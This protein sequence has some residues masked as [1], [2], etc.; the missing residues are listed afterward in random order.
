MKKTKVL[1]VLI[2]V[3]LVI[4]VIQTAPIMGVYGVEPDV[5]TDSLSN[6]DNVWDY[7]TRTVSTFQLDNVGGDRTVV[8]DYN[9]F[10][11]LKDSGGTM[12]A[13]PSL[14]WKVNGG[15]KVEVMAYYWNT[16]YNYTLSWSA[17]GYDY[18]VIDPGSMQIDLI[19]SENAAAKGVGDEYISTTE[20]T[21]LYTIDQ[22]DASARFLKVTWP[23]ISDNWKA[24]LSMVRMTGG[25]E[26]AIDM[27]YDKEVLISNDQTADTADMAAYSQSFDFDQTV[28]GNPVLMVSWGYLSGKAS[29]EKPYIVYEADHSKSF[30]A[31]FR[32]HESFFHMNSEINFYSSESLSGPWTQVYP[33]RQR[34]NSTTDVN[35]AHLN[36]TVADL[37]EGGRYVKIEYPF[38][39]D[40][41]AVPWGDGTPGTPGNPLTYMCSM[42]NVKYTEY[43]VPPITDIEADT[44]SDF[45]GNQESDTT[46]WYDY[47]KNIFDYNQKVAGVPFLALDWYAV[48][49]KET[50]PEIFVIYKVKAGSPFK[51]TYVRHARFINLDLNIKIFTS[52]DASVWEERTDMIFSSEPS[53]AAP[54]FNNEMLITEA[55]P[56]THKFVKVVYPNTKDYSGT[57][58]PVE[59]DTIGDP[60]TYGVGIISAKYNVTDESPE[61]D[62]LTTV[63]FEGDEAADTAKWA[64]YAKNTFDFVQALEG[65]P[66]LS[67]R[68]DFV[69]EKETLP[70]A[71]VVYKTAPGSPFVINSITH[72]KM[73]DMGK[74]Y[75]VYTSEDMA[76]WTEVTELDYEYAAKSNDWYD[77]EFTIQNIPETHQYVKIVWPNEKDYTG[78]QNPSREEV[79]GDPIHYAPGLTGVRLILPEPETPETPDISYIT[80][81]TTITYS[82]DQEA[83]SAKMSGYNADAIDFTQMLQVGT[84]NLNVLMLNYDFVLGQD[85]LPEAYVAYKVAS[86]SPFRVEGFNHSNALAL[87]LDFILMGSENGTDWTL[88]EDVIYVEEEVEDVM[89]WMKVGF[90]IEQ[91]PAGIQYVKIVWPNEKDYTGDINPEDSTTLDTLNYAPALLSVTFNAAEA[92]DD[93]ENPQ[94]GDNAV[95]FTVVL[96]VS[97][98]AAAAVIAGRKQK[99]K[100]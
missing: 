64:D 72:R 99:I 57:P 62:D 88:L 69:F 86:G 18:T 12:V 55:I 33:S 6:L 16:S 14:V 68:Y 22:I 7:N 37:P 15:A 34:V 23:I 60:I 93:E 53:E 29:V 84:T 82:G 35:V 96:L 20:T 30:M 91:L 51:L 98:V 2:S 11:T 13:R 83:D 9:A 26:N 17:N 28:D 66:F 59:G 49:G 80:G 19:S 56:A 43:V 45:Q 39:K 10:N 41:S 71:Y 58:D 65:L 4:S 27:T 100:A 3:L 54:G 25:T 31:S 36:Y 97:A 38:D 74:K 94:T 1:S 78:T 76:A 73:L 8:I 5:F 81:D 75:L 77:E 52:A 61:M 87:G 90:G 92:E 50:L 63:P 46:V 48:N 95:P 42:Y 85:E 40:I 67:L 24:Q 47:T 44:V 21:R 79:F 32:A 70:E 89:N